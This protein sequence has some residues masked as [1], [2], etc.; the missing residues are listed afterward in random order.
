MKLIDKIKKKLGRR[1]P[2]KQVGQLTLG[3]EVKRCDKCEREERRQG[4]WRSHFFDS[5]HRLYVYKCSSCEYGS[6][7][8]FEEVPIWD[9]CPNCGARMEAKP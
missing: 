9:Y 6:Y 8:G 2:S 1:S 3:V 7:H 4:E 5:V